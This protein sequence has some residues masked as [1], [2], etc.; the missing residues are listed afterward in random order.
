MTKKLFTKILT[1]LDKQQQY[2]EAQAKLLSELFEAEVPEY[3]NS[4]LTTALIEVLQTRF[5][6]EG[7]N[8]DIEFYMNELDFGRNYKPGTVTGQVGNEIGLSG[9]EKLYDHL[10]AQL[11]NPAPFAHG[12]NYNVKLSRH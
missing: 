9:H 4:R 2:D 11:P 5:P 8:C 1:A 10:I 6:P 3:D 7:H 12:P